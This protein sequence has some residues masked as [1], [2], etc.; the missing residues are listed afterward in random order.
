M[1][2]KR[3]SKQDQARRELAQRLRLPL[4]DI[5]DR[6][7]AAHFLGFKRVTSLSNLRANGPGFYVP[8]GVRYVLYRRDWLEHY[9]NR[10]A[11]TAY[12]PQS[13]PPPLFSGKH[14]NAEMLLDQLAPDDDKSTGH[15]RK[16]YIDGVLNGWK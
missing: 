9:A 16:A 14:A 12:G 5:L 11:G 2:R 4:A 6:E 1:P 8:P 7:E 3:I 13:W 15:K 10:K